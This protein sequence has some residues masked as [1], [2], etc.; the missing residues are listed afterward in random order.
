MQNK[1]KR[2]E[3][4]DQ[5]TQTSFNCHAPEANEVFLVGTF[6]NWDPLATRMERGTDGNWRTTV[7][8]PPGRYEYKFVVDGRWYCESDQESDRKSELRQD[9]VPNPFGTSNYI[10]EVTAPE[11][12]AVA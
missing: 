3:P 8:L 7:H 11:E 1:S 10:I 12:K 6:N 9:S 5:E 2:Q 4:E